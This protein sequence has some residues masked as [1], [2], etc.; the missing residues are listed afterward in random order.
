MFGIAHADKIIIKYLSLGHNAVIASWHDHR[1][2]KHGVLFNAVALQ[3]ITQLG[4]EQ[5]QHC[6]EAF[7]YRTL[8]ESRLFGDKFLQKRQNI[9]AKLGEI[10]HIVRTR[11]KPV[12]VPAK[13]LSFDPAMKFS[14]DLLKNFLWMPREIVGKNKTFNKKLMPLHH[15]QIPAPAYLLKVEKKKKIQHK[16][17]IRTLLRQSFKQVTF[18]QNFKK[19]KTNFAL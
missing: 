11:M 1:A 19:A 18:V 17:W 16:I 4:V 3:T 12:P 6:T 8:K 5:N 13:N 7:S 10:S 15:V 2:F 14:A 9:A